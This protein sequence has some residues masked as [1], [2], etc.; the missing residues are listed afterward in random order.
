MTRQKFDAGHATSLR[1]EKEVPAGPVAVTMLHEE[2]FHDTA[3]FEPAPVR[4]AQ[5][6]PTNKQFVE[7]EQD[8]SFAKTLTPRAGLGTGTAAQVPPLSIADIAGVCEPR[9]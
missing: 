8:T 7:E 2:P 1:E 6:S 5:W 4:P 3:R 9:R